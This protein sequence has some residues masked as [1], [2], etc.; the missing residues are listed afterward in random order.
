MVSA[1]SHAEGNSSDTTQLYTDCASAPSSPELPS[2]VNERCDSIAGASDS[3]RQRSLLGDHL[4]GY[5]NTLWDA[6]I[7]TPKQARSTSRIRNGYEGSS[8]R[9]KRQR[10]LE[11][12]VEVQLLLSIVD[13]YNRHQN[14]RAHRLYRW[15]WDCHLPSKLSPDHRQGERSPVP[16]VRCRQTISNPASFAF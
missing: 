9:C 10:L 2:L 14:D 7:S 13:I 16:D 15:L 3:W 11:S 12:H 6:T 4:S 8:D 5:S 1:S